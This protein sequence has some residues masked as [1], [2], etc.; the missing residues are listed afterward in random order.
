TPH[1][2][3]AYYTGIAANCAGVFNVYVTDCNGKVIRNK[4]RVNCASQHILDWYDAPSVYC[5][6]LN[7][8]LHPKDNRYK[9]VQNADSCFELRG[10][11]ISW[12][13]HDK[14]LIDCQH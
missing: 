12:S 9:Y 4:G 13:F 14:E 5:V 3:Q 10:N 6:H 1:M 8:Q 7:P 2:T 11:E